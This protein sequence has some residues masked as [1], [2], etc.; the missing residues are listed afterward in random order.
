MTRGW[1]FMEQRN[2]QTSISPVPYKDVIHRWNLVKKDPTAAVS[3]PVEPIVFWQ[4]IPYEYRQTIIDA[5]L[6]WNQ[7]FEKPA[8]K[9]LCRCVL[10]RIPLPGTLPISVIMLSRWVLPHHLW[11]YR[12]SF[13]NPVPARSLA[14]ILLLSGSPAAQHLSTMNCTAAR[15]RMGRI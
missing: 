11:R 12:P 14:P 15:V 9:M 10:C 3:E 2:D 4:R 5:G 8:S 7:A 6:K 13:V 1:V